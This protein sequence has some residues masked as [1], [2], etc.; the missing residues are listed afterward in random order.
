MSTGTIFFNPDKA[1]PGTYVANEGSGT[2]AVLSVAGTGKLSVK[3]GDSTF[4][5]EPKF[6]KFG[7]FYITKLDGET[8]YFVSQRENERGSYLM[9]KVAAD[10]PLEERGGAGGGGNAAPR[11]TAYG[12]R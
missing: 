8:R 6:N 11:A 4:E 3:C 10:R 9:A 2:A 1:N 5:V 7:K 12:S